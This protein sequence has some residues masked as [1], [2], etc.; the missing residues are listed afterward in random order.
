MSFPLDFLTRMKSKLL[1]K[2]LD[3]PDLQMYLEQEEVDEVAGHISKDWHK[4]GKIMKVEESTLE[5][6]KG[7]GK[8]K[9]ERKRK[10]LEHLI[11]KKVRFEDIIYGLYD[12]TN[13]HDPFING[14][15]EYLFRIRIKQ[16]EGNL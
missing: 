8:D 5:H 9:L 6:I 11:R 7:E 13:E 2:G 1:S 10:L 3:V 12:S 14:I 4:F 15:L 16:P